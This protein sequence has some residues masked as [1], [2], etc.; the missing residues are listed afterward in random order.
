MMALPTWTV[1]VVIGVIALVAILVLRQWYVSRGKPSEPEA[2]EQSPPSH[3]VEVYGIVQ[4][5]TY[6]TVCPGRWNHTSLPPSYEEA[7]KNSGKV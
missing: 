5:P 4:L 2:E 1:W 6:A 7:V 3:V